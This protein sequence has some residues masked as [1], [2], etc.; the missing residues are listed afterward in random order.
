MNITYTDEM[1]M[2]NV[3]DS[4]GIAW[5]R[6]GQT[7]PKT[8]KKIKM[9]LPDGSCIGTFN[10]CCWVE[11]PSNS[12]TVACVTVSDIENQ[13]TVLWTVTWFDGGYEDEF[14]LANHKKKFSYHTSWDAWLEDLLEEMED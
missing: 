4:F 7:L 1:A 3:I 6:L 9:Q 8:S 5:H 13:V 11:S 14:I 2:R 12:L 10:V